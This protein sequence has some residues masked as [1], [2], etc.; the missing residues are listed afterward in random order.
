MYPE[1]SLDVHVVHVRVVVY[2]S[3]WFRNSLKSRNKFCL[4]IQT[5]FQ[6]TN[7]PWRTD[8]ELT[9]CWLL[10]KRKETRKWKEEEDISN[11]TC[12]SNLFVSQEMSASDSSNLKNL[13]HIY[14]RIFDS[15]SLLSWYKKNTK[16]WFDSKFKLW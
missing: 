7:N 13:N 5:S 9:R 14:L 1:V 11:W 10:S 2:G 3:K 15:L 6:D 16:T 8:C 4:S 12:L